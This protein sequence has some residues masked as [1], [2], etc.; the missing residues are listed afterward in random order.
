MLDEF[1]ESKSKSAAAGPKPK[2]Q[3]LPDDLSKVSHAQVKKLMPKGGHLWKSH[4]AHCWLARMPPLQ[5]LS[6]SWRLHGE[7]ESIKM[8]VSHA[9]RQWCWLNGVDVKDCPMKGI[10]LKDDLRKKRIS[11]DADSS[12]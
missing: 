6:R 7:H 9:W 4:G 12:S 11:A 10:Y 5:P 1:R 3:S 2:S 8:V